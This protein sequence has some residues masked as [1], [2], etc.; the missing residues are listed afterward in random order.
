MANFNVLQLK[1]AFQKI[2]ERAEELP[3][4]WRDNCKQCG[5]RTLFGRNQP[6]TRG[7]MTNDEL[8][9]Y[10]EKILYFWCDYTGENPVS[11]LET[12]EERWVWQHIEENTDKCYL[13]E[14]KKI[15]IKTIMSFLALIRQ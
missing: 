6:T 9:Y 15:K 5:E 7:I 2:T 1:K 14:H 8:D 12:P 4:S 13:C 11:A 10:N 3:F